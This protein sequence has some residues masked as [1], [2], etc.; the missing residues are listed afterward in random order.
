MKLIIGI[1]TT[2]LISNYKMFTYSINLHT[3][4]LID[5]NIVTTK[6]NNYLLYGTHDL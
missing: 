1:F 3:Y 5:K 2:N 6:C 4:T